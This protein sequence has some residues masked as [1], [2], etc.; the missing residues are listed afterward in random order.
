MYCSTIPQ[1]K[2]PDFDGKVAVDINLLYNGDPAKLGQYVL[3]GDS[4]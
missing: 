1:I 3:T 4:G 2:D